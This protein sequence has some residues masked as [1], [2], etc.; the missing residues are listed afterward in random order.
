MLMK[1]PEL[2]IPII[3]ACCMFP[4]VSCAKSRLLPCIFYNKVYAQ[5]HKLAD[6][7]TS[8][9]LCNLYIESGE[10]DSCLESV[11]NTNLE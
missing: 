3:T 10:C 4:F 9:L 1:V 5:L 6:I 11:N 2:E 8:L 7:V